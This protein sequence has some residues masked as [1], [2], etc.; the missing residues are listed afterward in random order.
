L[1]DSPPVPKIQTLNN[2]LF[3][4]EKPLYRKILDFQ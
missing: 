2:E 3:G 4:L 1:E